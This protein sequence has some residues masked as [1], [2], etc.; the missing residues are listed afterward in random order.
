MRLR[1]RLSDGYSN[2]EEFTCDDRYPAFRDSLIDTLITIRPRLSR[3]FHDGSTGTYKTEYR[4]LEIHVWVDSI[5]GW[6]QLTFPGRYEERF[7][8]IAEF[9]SRC[10]MAGDATGMV[11]PQKLV[12]D[13]QQ[14]SDIEQV[15][16]YGPL[17]FASALAMHEAWDDMMAFCSSVVRDV[18]ND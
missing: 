10:R 15:D 16:R 17:M 1:F 7:P 11:F 13:G 18:C 8:E 3:R 12:T 9:R 14:L 5:N 4:R 2:S 6:S